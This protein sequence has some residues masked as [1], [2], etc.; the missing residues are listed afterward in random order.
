MLRD[1][2]AADAYAGEHDRYARIVRT[3]DGW[4]RDVFMEMSPD[5]DARRARALPRIVAIRREWWTSA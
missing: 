2:R 5:A 3:A 1:A 4:Y